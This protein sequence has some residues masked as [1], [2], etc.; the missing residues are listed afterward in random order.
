MRFWLFFFPVCLAA[1]GIVGC[2]RN[3]T[4]AQPP[5][6]H[7]APEVIAPASEPTLVASVAATQPADSSLLID[8]AQEWFPQAMLRLTTSD[9]KIVARLYSDDPSGVLSG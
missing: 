9:G 1:A 2:D 4:P 8:Q 5:A 6:T 7:P 3:P